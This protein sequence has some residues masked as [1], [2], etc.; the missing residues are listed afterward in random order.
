MTIIINATKEEVAQMFS[1][2]NNIVVNVVNSQATSVPEP[3]ATNTVLATPIT[4]E[5][6]K[7]AS[8]LTGKSQNDIAQFL[9]NG[10]I[11]TIEQFLAHEGVP[12]E[13]KLFVRDNF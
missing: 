8:D 2:A 5:M 11:T 3:Q 7:K 12:N 9:A 10:N 1:Q 13:Y 4:P 6:V